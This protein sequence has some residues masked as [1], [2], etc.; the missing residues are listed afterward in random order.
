LTKIIR[1][2]FAGALGAFLAWAIMEPTPLMPNTEGA[3]GYGVIFVIGLIFGLLLGFTLG[4]SEALGGLSPR[5]GG[6]T[7]VISALVGA[8]G[9]ILGLTFGNSLYS[10]F[11][12]LS[13]ASPGFLSFVLLLVGRAVG[14]ALIGGFVGLSQGLATSSAKKMRNGFIGGFLGGGVGGV[15]F[16]ILA[17]LNKGGVANLL[18]GMIR[19]T[20]FIITGGSVGLFIGLVSELAKKAWL[21]KM[22]GRNEGKEYELYKPVTVIGRSE[23]ADIPAFGDPDVAEKHSAVI[24]HGNRYY[25]EDAG[26]SFGTSL[27]GAVITDRQPLRSG[28][29]ITVGKTRFQFRDKSTPRTVGAASQASYTGVAIPTSNAVCP[30]CGTPRDGSGNCRCSVGG[31]DTGRTVS[32]AP[33]DLSATQIP[34][35]AFSSAAPI[36]GPRLVGISGTYGTETFA[37]N[38]SGTQIGRDS[39]NTIALGSD[40]TVSRTHTRIVK[41]GGEL[42]AYDE[43]SSNGT[44]VNNA[45]ITRQGLNNADVIQIGATRFKVE[46]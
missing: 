38:P 10:A 5:D 35:Q 36:S 4:L 34:T 27:N 39:T 23:F 9:G 46:L 3:V 7:V 44:F 29:I 13:D 11:K 33:A 45:R 26:S 43:G 12:G 14:W 28:D 20:S 17:M 42:V 21:L 22:V 2:T 15:V 30:F 1:H 31:A 32:Q 8:G 6:R 25:I 24:Q 40:R 41:E 37:I 18:P 16:E 19:F